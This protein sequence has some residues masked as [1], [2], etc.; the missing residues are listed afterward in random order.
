MAMTF[1]TQF[2][3]PGRERLIALYETQQLTADE[4]AEQLG[5]SKNVVYRWLKREGIKVRRGGSRIRPNP[6]KE[7]LVELYIARR[8]STRACCKELKCPAII[9]RRWF[10]EVG[11]EMRTIADAKAGQKPAPQT[12]EASVRSRRYRI[13]RGKPLTGYKVRPDGYVDIYEPKHPNAHKTGYVRE[14]RLVMEK[15]LGRYLLPTEDVHHKNGN[16]GD[17]RIENLELHASRADHIREHYYSDQ[18]ICK[19]TGRFLPAQRVGK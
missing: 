6:G 16:R 7:L 12:I 13:I 17:N 5:V 15:H 4:C 9:L 2:V 8:L 18:R 1:K 14:H 11:I 10:K 19:K 3:S